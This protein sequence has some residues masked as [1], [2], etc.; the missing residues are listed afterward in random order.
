MEN[1]T[2]I[3]VIALCFFCSSIPQENPQI[4]KLHNKCNVLPSRTAATL[5][6]PT[7][8]KLRRVAPTAL[9]ASWDPSLYS[10]DV[11]GYRVFYNMYVESQMDAWASV[12]IPGRSTT[13]KLSDL[14]PHSGYAVRV[15]AKMADGRYSDFSDVAVLNRIEPGMRLSALSQ[16]LCCSCLKLRE[17]LVGLVI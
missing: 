3:R 6:G 8:V 16:V 1:E 2:I 15:Q 4:K 9:E 14:E 7:N 17:F 12:D 13:H 11:V 5:L 10:S